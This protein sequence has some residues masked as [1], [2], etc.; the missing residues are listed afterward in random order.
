VTKELENREFK[1]IALQQGGHWHVTFFSANPGCTFANLG[2]LI[3]DDHDYQWLVALL[4]AKHEVK[5]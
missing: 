5:P 2:T 3:M 1:T 4:A